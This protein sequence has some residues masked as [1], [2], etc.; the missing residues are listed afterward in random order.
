MTTLS[1]DIRISANARDTYIEQIGFSRTVEHQA[2]KSF[3]GLEFQRTLEWLSK[4]STENIVW[5]RTSE[6]KIAGSLSNI[7]WD[8]TIEY[9][10]YELQ[11]FASG[12]ARNIIKTISSAD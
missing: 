9:N 4:Q 11:S 7:Q 12:Q 6:H 2:R 1:Y 3:E 8:R 10:A 5:S